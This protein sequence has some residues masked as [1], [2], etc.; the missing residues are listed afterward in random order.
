MIQRT[1]CKRMKFKS[2]CDGTVSHAIEQKKAKKQ[3]T[4]I[5]KIRRDK[6]RCNYQRKQLIL[7]ALTTIFIHFF[8]FLIL[9]FPMSFIH[10][11]YFLFFYDRLTR[12]PSLFH[13]FFVS[14][15]W[16]Q[17]KSYNSV[18]Q[19]NF[20]YVFSVSIPLKRIGRGTWCSF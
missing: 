12:T 11:I 7:R 10:F 18:F 15:L 1:G 4:E 5:I 8:S 16:I 9:F 3:R 14:R 20:S 17:I 13:I 19:L 6:K 2:S